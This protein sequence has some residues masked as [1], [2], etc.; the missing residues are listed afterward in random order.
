[1]SRRSFHY[2]SRTRPRLSRY[3]SLRNST[4][5][6]ARSTFAVGCSSARSG[7]HAATSGNASGLA[8]DVRGGA[9]GARGTVTYSQGFAAQLSDYI[10]GVLADDGRLKARTDG[11][12]SSID[13]LDN[14]QAALERRLITIEARY[15]AQFG[16]LDSLIASMN[17]TSSFLTQ[18]LAALQNLNG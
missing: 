3:T 14:Q 2:G 1:M 9:T 7:G 4:T 16:A 8:I 10:E 17:A 13:R 6:S 15:R 18:Q 12:D 5:A 11:I